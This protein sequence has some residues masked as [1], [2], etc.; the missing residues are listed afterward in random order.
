MLSPLQFQQVLTLALRAPTVHNTQPAICTLESPNLIRVYG[1]KDRILTVGDP[2]LRD[3]FASLGAVCE[4]LRLALAQRGIHA[5]VKYLVRDKSD[6][7][8]QKEHHAVAEIHLSEQKPNIEPLADFLHIRRSYRGKFKRA[9]PEKV[10]S[11][12]ADSDACPRLFI[13]DDQKFIERAARWY[14]AANQF[15]LRQKPY[16][17]ELYFWMR[18]SPR[19]PRWGSDGLNAD[20]MALSPIER[21]AASLIMLPQ[22]IV[23][24]MKLHLGPILISEA[25]QIKSSTVLMVQ[26]ADE[27]IHPMEVG[28]EFH[29]YWLLLAK[30]GFSACPLSALADHDESADK[31][32]SYVQKHRPQWSSAKGRIVNI[33]R[34]GV[35]P[36]HAGPLSPRITPPPVINSI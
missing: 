25:P 29:R 15:F 35:T 5:E 36:E 11:L 20:S 28:A 31:I 9:T 26:Y 2:S 13:S 24:L 4:G 30:H 16:A 7:D 19:H 8:M 17:E 34:C 21:M 10:Q 22:V 14:D 33:W 1:A 23:P 18:L 27:S 32:M 6:I 3:H 12:I